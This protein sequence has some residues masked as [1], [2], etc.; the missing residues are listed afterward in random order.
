[1]NSNFQIQYSILDIAGVIAI[2]F[3]LYKIR[4]LPWNHGSHSHTLDICLLRF[5]L[6]FNFVFAMFTGAIWFFPSAECK[7]SGLD[8]FFAFS[9]VLYC[10][11]NVLFIE[12]LLHKTVDKAE[13]QHG[14][15]VQITALKPKCHIL[16]GFAKVNFSG[17]DLFDSAEPCCLGSVH[18]W[19]PEPNHYDR[20]AE[21][22]RPSGRLG[23]RPR[24][25][26]LDRPPARHH[27]HHHLLQVPLPGDAGGVLEEQLQEG[28]CD[29]V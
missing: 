27:P 23:P 19:P 29:E 7:N 5:G 11:S 22:L 12:L 4:K 3:G 15:Q 2:C 9:S 18:L 16:F 10:S 20:R 17:C 6:F 14:R 8:L 26:H 25:L 13:V 24:R 28:V 21:I 1:M